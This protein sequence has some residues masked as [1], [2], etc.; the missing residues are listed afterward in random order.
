M[1]APD[2][3]KTMTRAAVGAG[4]LVLVLGLDFVWRDILPDS[5][6]RQLLMLA[7]CNVL[8][9]LPSKTQP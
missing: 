9:A 2:R 6:V 8:V 4:V 1:S 3:K 7:A 5:S